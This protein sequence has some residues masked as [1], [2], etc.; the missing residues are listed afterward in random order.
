MRSVAMATARTFISKR[1]DALVYDMKHMHCP[2]C[3]FLFHMLAIIGYGEMSSKDGD[4][5]TGRNVNLDLNTMHT[6]L[7]PG[8]RRQMGTTGK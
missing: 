5:P 4:A 2:Y 8:K 1:N 6:Y 7:G 3:L